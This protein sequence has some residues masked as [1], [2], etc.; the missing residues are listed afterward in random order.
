MWYV[1]WVNQFLHS[2]TLVIDDTTYKGPAFK[3]PSMPISGAEDLQKLAQGMEHQADQIKSLTQDLQQQAALIKS[4]TQYSQHQ[5][6]QLKALTQALQ[7]LV[8]LNK[9]IAQLS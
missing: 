7:E 3:G 2:E 9:S 6:A 1:L 5:A 8:A 4:L